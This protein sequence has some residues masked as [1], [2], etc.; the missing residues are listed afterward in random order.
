[1]ASVAELVPVVGVIAACEAV[2]VARATFYRHERRHVGRS[3]AQ[4]APSPRDEGAAGE[5]SEPAASVMRRQL[6]LLVRQRG[7]SGFPAKSGRTPP[8]LRITV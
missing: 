8:M 1:M 5:R 7:Y 4:P 3:S 6:Q 2:G